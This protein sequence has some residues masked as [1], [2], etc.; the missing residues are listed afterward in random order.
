[1]NQRQ[2]RGPLSPRELKVRDLA[3]KAVRAS[4]DTILGLLSKFSEGRYWAVPHP[5][6]G[7][8]LPRRGRGKEPD[9]RCFAAGV[10]RIRAGVE[11]G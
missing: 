6:C 10:A 4:R 5:L 7:L 2:E 9:W 3:D 11:T 8:P 1:M